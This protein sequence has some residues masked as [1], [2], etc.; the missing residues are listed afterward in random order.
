MAGEKATKYCE[1]NVT[2]LNGA[3]VSGRFHVEAR[4][5]STIRP[6]DAIR[7][8]KDGLLLLTDVQYATADEQR[9]VRAMLIPLRAVACIELPATRWLTSPLPLAGA[10]A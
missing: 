6:S 7:E 4:T 8:A 9:E 1:L 2:L 10:L 5:S 3:R